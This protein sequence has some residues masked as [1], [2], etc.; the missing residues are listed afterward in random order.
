MQSSLDTALDSRLAAGT[1]FGRYQ[2]VR[3]IGEGGMGVVYEALHVELRK[4]VA[5]KIMKVALARDEMARIRFVREG[6]AAARVRHAHVVDV[7]DV[8]NHQDVPYLV[9]EFLEG[10]ELEVRLRRAGRF[11]IDAALDILLPV[12]AAV[13][14]GH[15]QGVIHRDLKPQNIFLAR[16][17][18]GNKA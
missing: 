5:I 10:E 12:I 3:F 18:N 13:A 2:I 8:G 15:D 11:E 16:Q 4:R 17:A 14:A 7:S 1:T 6:E 9:M